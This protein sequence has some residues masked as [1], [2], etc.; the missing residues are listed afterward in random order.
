MGGVRGP[1]GLAGRRPRSQDERG[2]YGSDIQK[3][4]W[5]RGPETGLADRRPRSQATKTSGCA[6]IERVEFRPG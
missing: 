3:L 5:V 4:G 2:G 1:D 6:L